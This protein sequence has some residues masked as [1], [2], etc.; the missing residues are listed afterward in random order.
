MRTRQAVLLALIR[1][2][3]VNVITFYLF[4]LTNVNVI[5]E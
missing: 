3:D 5:E 1:L 2:A 4:R